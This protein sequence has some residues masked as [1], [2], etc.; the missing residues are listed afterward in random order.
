[1]DLPKLNY[2]FKRFI[3]INKANNI[4]SFKEQLKNYSLH[5]W[6]KYVKYN[7]N[8]YNRCLVYN[9]IEYDIF[10]MTWLPDQYTDFHGHHKKGCLMKIL[11]NNLTE[12]CINNGLEN[13]NTLNENNI[14][15]IDDTIGLHKIVNNTN[16]ISVSLHIYAKN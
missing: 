11:S 8:T 16:N 1:M 6:K 15:Y 5:D 4:K 14:T 12:Y 7:T 3:T 2:L 10:I 13:I 9:D